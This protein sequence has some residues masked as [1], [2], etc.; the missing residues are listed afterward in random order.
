MKDKV[1]GVVGGSDSSVV[2][3]LLLA[4]YAKKVYIIYRGEKVRPEPVNGKRMEVMK[5][6][7]IITN[8]NVREILGDKVMNRVLLDKSYGGKTELMLDG[9]YI[10]IGIVPNNSLAKKLGV[11]VDKDG[12][13]IVDKAS[14]TNIPGVFAAGDVTNNGW[15]QAIIGAAQGSFAANSVYN[16]LGEQ[17]S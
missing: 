13:I 10:A 11:V 2:E 15:K 6:I 1:V 4:E 17:R 8:T 12:F 3:A 16:F 9:I 7:E 14:R 5:N